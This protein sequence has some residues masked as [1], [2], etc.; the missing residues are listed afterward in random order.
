MLS[1]IAITNT[2]RDENCYEIFKRIIWATSSKK[3]PSNMHNMH[4]FKI[5]LLMSKVSSGPL[6][7]IQ[8]FLTLVLLNKLRC[9]AHF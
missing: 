5:I 8:T 9:H 7:S 2:F 4:T 6:L 3:V 1:G